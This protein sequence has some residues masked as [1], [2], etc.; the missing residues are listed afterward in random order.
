MPSDKNIRMHF[1]LCLRRKK[2]LTSRGSLWLIVKLIESEGNK[3]VVFV[4]IGNIEGD[5]LAIGFVHLV[6]GI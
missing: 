4:A 1:Y 5:D 3:L 2:P 6:D